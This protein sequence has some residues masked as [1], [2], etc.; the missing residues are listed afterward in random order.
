MT[1]TK[2]KGHISQ[3]FFEIF[4][5]RP[6]RRVFEILLRK[7]YSQTEVGKIYDNIPINQKEVS[8]IDNIP[9]KK[10][11]VWKSGKYK[12]NRHVQ[13][14]FHLLDK[15]L[16]TKL[17]T[18][19]YPSTTKFGKK[20]DYPSTLDRRRINLSDIFCDYI[21]FLSNKRISKKEVEII[22]LALKDE[23]IRKHFLE[24][25]DIETGIEVFLQNIIHE[26][27]LTEGKDLSKFFSTDVKSDDYDKY[28]D[29]KIEI[30]MVRRKFLVKEYMHA[31]NSIWERY[32][33]PHF[34]V[35]KDGKQHFHRLGFLYGDGSSDD[36]GILKLQIWL[37][38][39]TTD[40]I[41]RLL[42]LLP[43]WRQK[44]FEKIEG[45]AL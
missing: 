34:D 14:Y 17:I 18:R 9:T 24:M 1:I 40:D 23:D 4:E 8:N 5:K 10:K 38:F 21:S 43:K 6:G 13:F 32:F 37:C 12:G 45:N 26:L 15:Y 36:K 7:W 25:F 33:F 22:R 35:S 41:Q 19:Y 11:M 42:H 20:R 16:E 27:V 44:W 29:F 31:V 2:S 28:E 3:N 30:G 39:L